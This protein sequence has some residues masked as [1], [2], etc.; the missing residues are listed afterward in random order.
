MSSIGNRE[1]RVF[2]TMFVREAFSVVLGA[3]ISL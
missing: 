1:Q 3:G 2:G